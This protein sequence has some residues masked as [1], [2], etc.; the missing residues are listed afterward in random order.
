MSKVGERDLVELESVFKALAPPAAR[1][2]VVLNARGEDDGRRSP[3]GF[4]ARGDD[5]PSSADSGSG[6]VRSI[7]RSREGC[8]GSRAHPPVVGGWLRWFVPRKEEIDYEPARHGL[9]APGWSSPC[10][11]PMGKDEKNS[12]TARPA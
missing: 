11:I 1:I 4:P 8:T 12:T 5:Q 7:D 2:L 6:L 10:I 9:K 3:A